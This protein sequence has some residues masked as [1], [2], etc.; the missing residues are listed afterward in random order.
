M[1]GKANNYY[2]ACCQKYDKINTA[3]GFEDFG[4][5]SSVKYFPCG[6]FMC[7]QAIVT[8]IKKPPVTLT[9]IMKMA[10]LFQE[11]FFNW[12]SCDR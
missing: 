5:I 1:Q 2:S 12:S 8:A 9:I 10:L 7:R 3:G 11:L 6:L 4:S